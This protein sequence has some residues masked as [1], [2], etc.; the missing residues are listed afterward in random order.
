MFLAMRNVVGSRLREA[1]HQAGAGVTQEQLAA[2]LQSQG[3]DIDRT[4][5]SKIETGKR[6][7]MD[8]EIVAICQALN[9]KIATLFGEEYVGHKASLQGS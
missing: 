5:I 8:F 6:P 9:I 1:R 7:V 3:I 2:R 4:A